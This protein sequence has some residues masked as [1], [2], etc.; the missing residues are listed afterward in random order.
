MTSLCW[1]SLDT[2]ESVQNDAF[3]A[4]TLIMGTARF[5]SMRPIS[6]PGI[7]FD[8]RL[9]ASSTF[10]TSHFCWTLPFLPTIVIYHEFEVSS[11]G[12]PSFFKVLACILDFLCCVSMY[13]LENAVLHGLHSYGRSPVCLLMCLLRLLFRKKPLEQTVHICILSLESVLSLWVRS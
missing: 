12:N 6:C 7:H 13:I 11:K 1:S 8:K 10:A 2:F 5:L 3:T 4:F 9:F